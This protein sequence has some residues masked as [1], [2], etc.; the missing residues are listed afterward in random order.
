MTRSTI[1]IASCS[2][3]VGDGEGAALGDRALA[4]ASSVRNFGL[5]AQGSLEPQGQVHTDPKAN[6]S[7]RLQGSLVEAEALK[8]PISRSF[9]V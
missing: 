1:A 5:F 6:M 9:R 3:G 8:A 4:G 7:N 2:G